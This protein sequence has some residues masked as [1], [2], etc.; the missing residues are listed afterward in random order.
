MLVKRRM[1]AGA[2]GELGVSVNEGPGERGRGRRARGR[3]ASGSERSGAALRQC[4]APARECERGAGAPLP[5]P[6]SPP[7]SDRSP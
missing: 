6:P 4:P 3:D 5:R 2:T 1:R 7:S